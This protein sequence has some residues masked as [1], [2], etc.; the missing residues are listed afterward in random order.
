MT[1]Q[2]K[3]GGNLVNRKQN[4]DLIQKWIAIKK[5]TSNTKK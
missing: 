4:E 2:Q 1:R 5:T 3:L